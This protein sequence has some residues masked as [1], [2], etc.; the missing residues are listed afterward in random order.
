MSSTAT[1]GDRW[2]TP[3]SSLVVVGASSRLGACLVRRALA[4]GLPAVATYR[5][6]GT[7]TELRE[8]LSRDASESATLRLRQLDVLDDE[9]LAALAAALGAA[10]ANGGGAPLTLVY[11]CGLWQYGAIA[12]QEPE[13]FDR[14]VGVGL[15][16]PFLLTAALLRHIP[17]PLQIILVTGL[18][19][20]RNAVAHHALYSLVADGVYSLVRAVGAEL[21]GSDRWIT[22]VA[23]GLYDKGQDY[24]PE[25]VGKLDTGRPGNIEE[26][27][28]VIYGLARRP[29]A[30]TNGS[31]IELTGGLVSYQ[32][33]IR[34]L[35]ARGSEVGP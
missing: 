11:C 6:P 21:A 30:A 12:A 24:V 16:A 17:G 4:E 8:S 22:G 15:R 1:E 9:A 26:P 5:R 3:A 25:L 32:D 19:G 28:D 23:L 2:A 13:E 29:M 10:S 7:E 31:M 34:H 20:G 27:A 35:E 14:V 33:V 18:G